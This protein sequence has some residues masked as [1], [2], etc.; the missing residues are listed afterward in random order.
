MMRSNPLHRIYAER[1]DH[2]VRVRVLPKGFAAGR[3]VGMAVLGTAAIGVG[4]A[5]AQLAMCRH[6][7]VRS[8]LLAARVERDVAARKRG[9]L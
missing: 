6:D 5:R 1:I 3:P 9:A 7:T 4:R 8:D 2:A